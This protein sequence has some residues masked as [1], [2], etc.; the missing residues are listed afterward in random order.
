VGKDTLTREQMRTIFSDIQI[1]FEFNS[2]ILADISERVDKWHPKQIISGILA[3]EEERREREER[4]ERGVG[5][6]VFDLK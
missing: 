2:T 4:S 1:I 3:E 6:E 5:G